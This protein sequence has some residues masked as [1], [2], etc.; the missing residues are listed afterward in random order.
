VPALLSPGGTREHEASFDAALARARDGGWEHAEVAGLTVRV[1][2]DSQR[3]VRGQVAGLGASAALI[4]AMIVLGLRSLRLGLLGMLPN[5]LSCAVIY[6][7]LAVLGRPLTVASAMIGTVFLG[8]VVDDTVHLLHTLR[9]TRVAGE[10]PRE[11]MARAL[12]R[13]GRPTV[14]SSVTL[15]F[16]FAAC[17]TGRLS[18]TREFGALA[19]AIVFVALGACLTFLP[20]LLFRAG[21]LRS[22]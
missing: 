20:A 11:A 5:L 6:G 16:G 12:R 2:R 18:T 13:T 19:M 22:P 3:L 14:T 8:L 21:H 17:L 1:A 7:A 15:A 4:G 9:H 10:S